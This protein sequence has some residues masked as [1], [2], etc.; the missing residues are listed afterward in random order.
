MDHTVLSLA[1]HHHVQ[2]CC[3]LQGLQE[4]GYDILSTGGSYKAIEAADVSV[5]H[6]EQATN[7]PEM[8]EGG[9]QLL[10][11]CKQDGTILDHRY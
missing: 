5:S 2:S 11:S 3:A 9:M 10:D 4:Q 1:W 8:L 7:F 6:V